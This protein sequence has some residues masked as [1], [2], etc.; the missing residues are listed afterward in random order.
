L[1]QY[2]KHKIWTF[3]YEPEVF[4]DLILN[5]DIKPKL[6]KSLEEVPN[7]LLYGTAG[8]GKG[9]FTKILLKHTGYDHLW[10]NASDETGIDVIRDKVK[11]F[12]T[13]LGFTDLKIV[14]FNESDSLSQGAQGAQ[15]MLKQLIEDVHKITRF[16]FLSNSETLMM[17]ELKSRCWVIKV[18]NPPAIDIYKFCENILKQEHV[19]YT[20][21]ILL[22]IV[23]KCYPDIRKT[24]QTCQEN[25]I[26]KK[27]VGSSVSSA[28]DVYNSI[29]E[30]MKK[31]DVDFIRKTL[32]SSFIDYKELYRYLY[33][34]I[35][36]FEEPGL[37]ILD[38]GEYMYRDGFVAIK[39]INFV[40][41]IVSMLNNGSI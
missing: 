2:D 31:G 13:A 28:E 11:S 29:F 21:K 38:I 30:G 37:A 27:L 14:V 3:K 15:K 24:I 34:R 10:I 41:M 23:K 6:K 16:V 35:D 8:V 7:L 19:S 25:T 12:S 1:K 22:E 9:T 36:D 39:E 26:N 33:N 4:D 18:D 5:N 32:R 40:T 20:K 17:E